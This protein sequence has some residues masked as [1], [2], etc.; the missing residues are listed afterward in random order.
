MKYLVDTGWLADYLADDEGATF[1]ERLRDQGLALSVVTF[2]E[3]YEG[4]I[5]LVWTATQ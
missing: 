3:L 4:A 1:I 2:M 5:H